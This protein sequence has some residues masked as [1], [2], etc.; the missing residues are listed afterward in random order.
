[1]CL[2]VSVGTCVCVC[3]CLCV[4]VYV[5]CVF[6]NLLPSLYLCL[7]CLDVIHELD[8]RTCTCMCVWVCVS[9]DSGESDSVPVHFPGFTN[10]FHGLTTQSDVFSYKRVRRAVHYLHCVYAFMLRV[11][12]VA[13]ALRQ[14]CSSTVLLHTLLIPHTVMSLLAEKQNKKPSASKNLFILSPANIHETRPNLSL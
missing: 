14:S 4:C 1:M 13:A 6:S 7:F 3:V 9:V 8:L 12:L 11:T 2:Y 10:G 5:V